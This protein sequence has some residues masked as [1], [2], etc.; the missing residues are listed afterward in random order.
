MPQPS[1]TDWRRYRPRHPVTVPLTYPRAPHEVI[2]N[3]A[4]FRKVWRE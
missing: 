2:D 4:L 3:P 1:D